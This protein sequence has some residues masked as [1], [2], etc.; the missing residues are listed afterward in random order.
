MNLPTLAADPPD[1]ILHDEGDEVRGVAGALRC[2][3][4]NQELALSA[5]TIAAVVAEGDLVAIRWTSP[6]AA[7]QFLRLRGDQIAEVCVQPAS[8]STKLFIASPL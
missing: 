3:R 7:I 4:Q 1:L 2:L 5:V 8:T 6:S